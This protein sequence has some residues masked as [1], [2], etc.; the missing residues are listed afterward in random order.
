MNMRQIDHLLWPVIS[1]R[2]A[3]CLALFL[4]WLSELPMLALG[5]L[6]QPTLAIPGY[7]LVVLGTIAIVVT[8]WTLV[9]SRG[10]YRMWLDT[11]RYHRRWR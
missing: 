6:M 8:L 3:Y 2:W 11:N 4:V 10:R 7:V 9:E 5:D 1:R